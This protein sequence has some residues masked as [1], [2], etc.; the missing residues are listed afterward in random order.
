VGSSPIRVLKADW[1]R[2][3]CTTPAAQLPVGTR[4]RLRG[5]FALDHYQW[6]EFLDRYSDPPDLF[7]GVRVDR[8][9]QVQIPERFV[10]RSGASRS[11]PTAV[12][13][14]AYGPEHTR[15][16]RTVND[17]EQW[18]AFSLLDL[19]VLPNGAGPVRPTFLGHV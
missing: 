1:L 4:V 14:G 15:E 6:V 7:Y 19:K 9:R 2:F 3:Y 17:D 13:P 11:Y 18:P 5:R 16:V 12:S 8:I 10:Q